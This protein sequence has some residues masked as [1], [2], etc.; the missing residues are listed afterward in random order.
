MYCH[1]LD[2]PH[3]LFAADLC[4]IS[5]GSSQ[6]GSFQLIAL[7]DLSHS[8]VC[9]QC[10]PQLVCQ[11]HWVVQLP[12]IL[13]ISLQNHSTG[14][15]STIPSQ[16]AFPVA[17]S[18]MRSDETLSWLRYERCVVSNYTHICGIDHLLTLYR[19]LQRCC[20]K[21]EKKWRKIFFLTLQ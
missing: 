10:P 19:I 5:L 9:Q 6:T 21:T 7:H 8:S 2:K 11:L 17:H 20:R 18:Y 12:L 16:G 15:P 1:S 4:S 3:N 13:Q 14:K